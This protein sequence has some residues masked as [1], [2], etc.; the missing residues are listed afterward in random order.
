MALA[1]A[2]ET[3][4]EGPAGMDMDAFEAALT[5]AEANP[6]A[7]AVDRDL[8]AVLAR[9]LTDV[10]RAQALRL[11]AT[12]RWKGA[13]NKPGA[14]ADLETYLTLRPLDPGSEQVRTDQRMIQSEI[15]Q[16]EQRINRLQTLSKWFDDTV[17]I[18]RIDEAAER[19]K[20]SGLTPT[21]QQVYTL[22]E[23]GYICTAAAG[24]EPIHKYGELPAYASNLVWCPAA[25]SA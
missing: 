17:A 14:V 18:G 13:Y 22:R 7:A 10:Q 4:P 19:Y 21:D 25:P 15:A 2:C 20:T 12:K 9:D 23:A 6:S 24:G 3:V 1:T 16:H 8:T 5:R 11:R